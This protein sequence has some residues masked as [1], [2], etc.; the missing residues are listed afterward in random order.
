M[1]GCRV[2]CRRPRW[3]HSFPTF[4]TLQRASLVNLMRNTGARINEALA[5][6]L[7]DFVLDDGG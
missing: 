6:T 1:A 3:R 4:P 2:I 7:A 5:L